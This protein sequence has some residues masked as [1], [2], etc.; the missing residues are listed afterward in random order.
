[1]V[2]LTEEKKTAF[3]YIEENSVKLSNL[4]QL[5]WGYAETALREYKSCEALV[6]WH[7][8]EGFEVEEGIAGMPTAY[9]A[10]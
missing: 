8:D 6:K 5:I 9:L 7:R 3:N 10:T 2:E 1:M 4:H